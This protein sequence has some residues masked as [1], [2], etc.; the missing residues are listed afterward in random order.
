MTRGELAALIGVRF[1]TVLAAGRPQ[2]GV[3]ATDVRHHWAERW[4]VAVTRAGIMNVYPN[5]TFQPGAVVRR[6]DLAQVVTRM[7]QVAGVT[8]PPKRARVNVSDVGPDHLNYR[9]VAVAIASGAMTLADGS[10]FRP[11]RPVSGS[12]AIQ[13]IERL[14][15]LTK[16]SR[17]THEL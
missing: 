17:G 12:E 10:A 5:H 13:V 14:E 9:D 4:I 7:L 8:L 3:V 16:R 11:A 15:R 2:S 6:V 1:D